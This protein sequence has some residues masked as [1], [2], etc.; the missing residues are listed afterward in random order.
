MSFKSATINR[1]LKLNENRSSFC[2]HLSF[3]L[4][5][6][7]I[8]HF[9]FIWIINDIANIILVNFS[10]PRRKKTKPNKD[11]NKKTTKKTKQRQSLEAPQTCYNWTQTNSPHR[12]CHNLDPFTTPHLQGAPNVLKT[13]SLACSNLSFVLFILAIHFSKEAVS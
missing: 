13:I 1:P 11:K 12:F 10:K 2:S 8:S 9:I 3:L 4:T 6:L 7:L 5:F